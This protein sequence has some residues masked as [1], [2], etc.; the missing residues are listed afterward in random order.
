MKPAIFGVLASI[1]FLIFS[2]FEWYYM[3]DIDNI[4][5]TQYELTAQFCVLVSTIWVVLPIC[6]LCCVYPPEKI[7][8]ELDNTGFCTSCGTSGCLIISIVLYIFKMVM[9]VELYKV[10]CTHRLGIVIMF[11]VYL[12]LVFAILMLI[13]MAFMACFME[14]CIPK[15]SSKVVPVRIVVEPCH[16]KLPAYNDV[17]INIVQPQKKIPPH[18]II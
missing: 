12:P 8:I 3:N 4:E 14:K 9:S 10:E 17:T 18:I 6:I 7:N 1:Y 13:V 2:G 15:T 16:G 5:C 11:E